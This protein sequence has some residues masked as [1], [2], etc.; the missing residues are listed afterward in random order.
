[1]GTGSVV[2]DNETM[3]FKSGDVIGCYHPPN[4]HYQVNTISG[5]GQ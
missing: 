5:N 2:D 1:M 4:V 3:E